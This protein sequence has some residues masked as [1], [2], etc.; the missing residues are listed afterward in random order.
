MQKG[1]EHLKSLSTDAIFVLGVPTYYPKYGFIPADKQ[2][3]YPDLLTMPEA[4]MVLE[5]NQGVVESLN[6]ET[7]AITPFMDPIFW[8][9]SGRG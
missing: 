4:W 1:I 3:P 6:G 9:T 2:T 7:Q 8:D 5:L